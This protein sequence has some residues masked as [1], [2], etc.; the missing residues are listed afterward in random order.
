[1]ALKTIAI[2]PE[3]FDRIKKRKEWH[4][5]KYNANKTTDQLLNDLLDATREPEDVDG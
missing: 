4:K 5:E 3:T 1:M 2:N